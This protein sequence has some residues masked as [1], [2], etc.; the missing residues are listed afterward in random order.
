MIYYWPLVFKCKILLTAFSYFV[1]QFSG[2]PSI[3][4]TTAYIVAIF[5]LMQSKMFVCRYT[6]KQRT[7]IK[8]DFK[9]LGKGNFY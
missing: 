6:N 5:T 2:L 9:I 8:N 3:I 7:D 4:S 1:S